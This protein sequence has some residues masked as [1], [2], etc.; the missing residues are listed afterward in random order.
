MLLKLGADPTLATQG[1]FWEE[2]TDVY[3]PSGNEHKIGV[4]L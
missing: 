2:Q 4:R 3:K 1:D